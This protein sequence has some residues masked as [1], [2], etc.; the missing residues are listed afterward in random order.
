MFF[1]SKYVIFFFL[2]YVFLNVLCFF[3]CFSECVTDFL[4]VFLDELY[5]F[6]HVSQNFWYLKFQ[7]ILI[8]FLCVPA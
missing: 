2:C 7:H 6:S 5:F 8:S 3:F 4:S 1:F